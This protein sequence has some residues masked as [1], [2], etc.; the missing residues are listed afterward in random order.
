MDSIA[1]CEVCA[2]YDNTGNTLLLNLTSKRACWTCCDVAPPMKL[3]P[4]VY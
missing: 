2:T 1:W 4:F 3:Y